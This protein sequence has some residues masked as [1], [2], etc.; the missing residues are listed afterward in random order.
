MSWLK[1]IVLGLMLSVMLCSCGGDN[2]TPNPEDPLQQS[3]VINVARLGTA[4]YL[5]KN[6]NPES[7][8]YAVKLG[9][10]MDKVDDEGA[11]SLT[12]AGLQAVL[13]AEIAK[14]FADDLTPMQQE[15]IRMLIDTVILAAVQWAQTEVEN[16]VDETYLQMIALAG[17]HIKDIASN[18]SPTE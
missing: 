15:S 9:D 6:S 14:E 17:K 4:A 8:A 1:S 5:D 18:Y 16:P 10:I 2:W 3:I 11:L 12:V 13:H 7:V